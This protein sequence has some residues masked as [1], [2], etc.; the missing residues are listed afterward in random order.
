MKI[1]ERKHRL[2]KEAYKSRVR[3]AFTICVLNKRTLFVTEQIF[4]SMENMLLNSLNKFMCDAHIYLFMPDHG[5]LLIEGKTEEA[6]LWNGVV[7]FKRKSGFW[8]AQNH[9]QEEWQKISTTT[10]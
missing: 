8:L 9:P 10:F 3:C 5:H 2:S 4:R 1:K 7:D 6:D